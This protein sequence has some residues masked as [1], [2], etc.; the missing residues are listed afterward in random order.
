MI[1]NG[2]ARWS[3]GRK[4]DR[5]V[6]KRVRKCGLQTEKQAGNVN[7]KAGKR[8]HRQKKCKQTKKLS[9]EC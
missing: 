5:L 2:Q 6:K 1:A 7:L 9:A 4:V 3:A 8:D